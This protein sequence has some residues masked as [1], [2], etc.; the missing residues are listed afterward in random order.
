MLASSFHE[1][2]YD[3]HYTDSMLKASMFQ[4]TLSLQTRYLY[5]QQLV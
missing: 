1:F 5:C 3:K 4:F 2:E